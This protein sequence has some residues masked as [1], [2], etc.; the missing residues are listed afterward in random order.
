M[1]DIMP[2]GTFSDRAAELIPHAVPD[3]AAPWL[4]ADVTLANLEAAGSNRGQPMPDKILVYALPESLEV[5]PRLG[6][7]AVN[8]ANNHSFD[9]GPEGLE[10]TK[11]ILRSMGIGYF[12]A[13]MDLEEAG[14]PWLGDTPTGTVAALGFSWTTE[15]V[16]SAPAATETTPGINPLRMDHVHQSIRSVRREHDPDLLVVSLHWGEGMSRYPRPDAVGQ[17][18]AMLASGADIV[19]GHHPHCLQPYEQTNDGIVFYSLG[20]FIASPY[21]RTEGARLTYGEGEPRTRTLRERQTVV[22]N[23]TVDGDGSKEVGYLPLVQDREVPV[24]HLA[25][26]RDESQIRQAFETRSRVLGSPKYR[27]RYGYLRRVDEI[28]SKIEAVREEGFGA[29]SWKTPFRAIRRLIT[30]R[31]LH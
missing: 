29:L 5:L 30:G 24:L 20:N 22:V 3:D 27:V 4:A 17:A 15:W 13:G 23:V 26:E 21:R 16:Q 19:M 1:G 28:N 14:A 12:G 9:Y 18:H 6:V 8:L 31:N 2:G 25:N 7:T 11:A 10:D